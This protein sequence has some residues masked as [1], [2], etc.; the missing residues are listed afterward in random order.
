M[1]KG[2]VQEDSYP[3]PIA[4]ALQEAEQACLGENR[5]ACHDAALALAHA[6]A[7]YLG[8]VA[9]GQY[10][11]ALYTDQIEAD[12]TLSRS[13]R[14]LRRVLPGQWLLW[15]ARGLASTPA[16]PVAG[17]SGWYSRPDTGALA[18][19]YTA[20][21][22]VMVE[23]LGYAGE[24]GPR[25][26]VSPRLFLELLDQYGVRR[27][28]L[29]DDA[30][31]IETTGEI[32]STILIGLRA[33]MQSATFLAEYQLYTP[34]QRKLLMGLEAT[35]PMPPMHTPEGAEETATLLLYPPGEKPDYTKR[36]TLQAERLPLF[37][38][39]PLLV[40]LYCK[41]CD[42]HRVAAL[43]EVIDNQPI[44]KGLDPQCNHVINA[45]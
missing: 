21:R 20:V 36:P 3:L 5:A 15:A 7:Y 41:E 42:T 13:L 24:Y 28:K 12:P 8:S 10:F 6:L 44:Y 30:L 26:E 38:L 9:V 37:P 11:Q 35:T 17:L 32:A 40:Y 33:L 43:H 25:E 19:A 14:S 4:R 27:S 34:Q 16:G 23:R 22:D 2:G 29:P 1:Q 31:P 18:D 39:D 45:G